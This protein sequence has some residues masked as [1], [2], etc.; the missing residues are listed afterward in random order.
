[1]LVIITKIIR[2]Q[3]AHSTPPV[4]AQTSTVGGSCGRRRG[5]G[6]ADADWREGAADAGA[7]EGSRPPAGGRESRSPT[8]KKESVIVSRREDAT[9][10]T[11]GR[12]SWPPI[13]GRELE[14]E[15][16]I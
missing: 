4:G 10:T 14:E 11:R 1:V 16:P 2:G 12:G 15:H 7:E 8:G 13:G 9:A 3:D 6:P 5:G